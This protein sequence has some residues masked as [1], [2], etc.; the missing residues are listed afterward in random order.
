MD[1]ID[2]FF[3]SDILN[4]LICFFLNCHRHYIILPITGFTYLS[5][6]VSPLSKSPQ[7]SGIS[8]HSYTC[9]SHLLDHAG[10]NLLF[11]VVI[12]PDKQKISAVMLQAVE[13][14]FPS[15]LVNRAPG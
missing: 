7:I 4:D 12:Y 2:P 9:F 5:L 6:S 11:F 3:L 8:C 13:I 14:L 1:R 15:N 10:V